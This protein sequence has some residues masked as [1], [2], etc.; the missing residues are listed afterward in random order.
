[1]L[2]IDSVSKKKP[3][4]HTPPA[5]KKGLFP[6]ALQRS[7]YNAPGNA[8]LKSQPWWR[9]EETGYQKSVILLQK[10]WKV[11]RDEVLTIVDKSAL[12][13]DESENLREKGQWKQFTLWAQGRESSGCRQ[14]PKTCA[15]VKQIPEAVG[16]V[17]GQIKFSVLH[18]HTH[19]WPHTGPTNV[20][21]RMHL[22]LV[23]PEGASIRVGEGKPRTWKE[24]KVIILDDSWEHEVWHDGS[25]RRIILIVDVWHP[26]LTSSQ[27]SQVTPM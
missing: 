12:F 8:V 3:K 6:S 23:C 18:P 10:N 17:R 16:N 26:E 25:E 21:L 11:I 19:V 1:M 27:K 2:Y 20:R 7:Q 9:V 4:I 22:G 24:G 14:A 5:R 15:I 13:L